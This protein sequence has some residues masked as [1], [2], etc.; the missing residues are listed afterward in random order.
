MANVYVPP[1]IPPTSVSILVVD[2]FEPWR[3]KSAPCSKHVPT[4]VSWQKQ[5][6]DWKPF[7][8][9]RNCNQI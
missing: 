7:K 9:P 4:F 1:T 8:K 3:R 6:T 2:D 5:G